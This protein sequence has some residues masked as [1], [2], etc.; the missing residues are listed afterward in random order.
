MAPTVNEPLGAGKL[1]RLILGAI[2]ALTGA[3]LMVGGGVLVWAHATQRDDHGFYS[4]PSRHFSTATA[5]MIT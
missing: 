5:A 1:L 2:C 3:A 4:T